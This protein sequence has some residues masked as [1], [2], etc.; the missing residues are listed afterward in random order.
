MIIEGAQ[1]FAAAPD[2]VWNF[3]M[4]AEVLSRVMPGTR[5]LRQTGDGQYS[6]KM[7]VKIGPITAAEFVLAIHLSDMDRP[8]RYVMNV[9]AN[10]KLG[11]TRGVARVTLV[12][13][14]AGT[15]MDYR[16]DLQMGGKIASVGQRLLDLVS[17]TMLKNGMEALVA[18]VDRRVAEGSAS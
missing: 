17:R 4:D 5:D 1:V 10:G 11:F 6:G 12:P 8:R 9:D 15:R 2:V 3:L 13:E 14:G 7:A 18:E 16:A